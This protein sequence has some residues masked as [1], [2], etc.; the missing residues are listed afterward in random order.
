MSGGD[1]GGD[2][3]GGDAHV[4]SGDGGGGAYTDVGN[5]KQPNPIDERPKVNGEPTIDQ[6]HELVIKKNNAQD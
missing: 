6:S 5:P 4:S 3:G 2:C 1:G